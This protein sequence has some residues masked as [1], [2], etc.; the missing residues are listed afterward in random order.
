M[1]ASSDSINA[2]TSG[3]A[4]SGTKTRSGQLARWASVAAA[5]AALPHERDRQGR[6]PTAHQSERFSGAQVQEDAGEVSTLVAPTDAARLILHPHRAGC[7]AA[8]VELVGG[9]R[10]H[11][12]ALAN[13][14]GQ[15]DER[16]FRHPVR[17]AERPPGHPR[18]IRHQRVGVIDRNPTMTAST[19]ER[20]KHVTAVGRRRSRAGE[21][22]R[23]GDVDGRPAHRAAPAE[24]RTGGVA[25]YDATALLKSSIIASQTLR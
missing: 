9:E 10:G 23:H 20:V 21:R 18:A 17:R 14:A 13:L 25:H 3:A 22:M 12:D 7:A 1:S 4:H 6:S 8:Q 2:I 11:G 19:D 16:S 15:S 5:R 24:Y